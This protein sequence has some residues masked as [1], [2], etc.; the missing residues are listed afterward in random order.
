MQQ[1]SIS[2]LL[3]KHLKP[4][5]AYTR[6]FYHLQKNFNDPQKKISFALFILNAYKK[7]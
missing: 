2:L 4:F 6:N 3:N 5:Q 7:C 1:G